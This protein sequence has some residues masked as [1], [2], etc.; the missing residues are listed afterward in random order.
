MTRTPVSHNLYVSLLVLAGLLSP[1]ITVAAE[2]EPYH[3]ETELTLLLFD[4]NG[5]RH[6]LP[7]YR[8]KVV[9][10][11][12]WASWCPPCIHEM[13]ELQKLKKSFANRP[14]V[15]LTVN[16]A[17]PK[18]RVSQFV[19]SIRL[20]LPVLLDTSSKTYRRWGVSILPTS[21][22]IDS[23]G[24]VRYR[25]RGNPGWDSTEILSTINTMLPRAEKM[26]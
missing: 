11:N 1:T 17:E 6:T 20:D 24:R 7:D 26:R 23:T 3:S 25:V 2:S 10:V 12:F 21:F 14:F 16:V 9:L 19:R 15:I 8:G 4:L 22:L 5:K 13:P 18:D